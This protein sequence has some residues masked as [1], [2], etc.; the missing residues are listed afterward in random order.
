MKLTH[1]F[2]ELSPEKRPQDPDMDGTGLRFR[3][4]STVASFP[5]PCPRRFVSPMPRAVPA[6]TCR[7][8]S[9]GRS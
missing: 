6:S 2:E 9:T 1:E 8:P 7:S 3:P 4:L 5:T